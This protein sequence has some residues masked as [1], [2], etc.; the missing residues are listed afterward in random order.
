MAIDWGKTIHRL[1]MGVLL[2]KSAADIQKIVR[3]A[4]SHG[5]KVAMRGHGCSAY[6]QAQVEG[7]IVI[8]SA[9]LNRVTWASEAE[10]DCQPGATW[11]DALNMALERSLTPPVLPDTLF[12][13]IGGTLSVG[14]ISFSSYRHGGAVDHV[15]EI[16]VVTGTGELVTCSQSSRADL[17][18]AVLAGMG[19]CGLIVRARIKLIAAPRSVAVRRFTY[20]NRAQFLRDM[21]IYSKSEPQG[22]VEGRLVRERDGFK[23]VLRCMNWLFQSSEPDAPTWLSSMGGHMDGAAKVISY[24]DYAN[25]ITKRILDTEEH[26]AA[27]GPRPRVHAFV[28]QSAAQSMLDFLATDVDAALGVD[29]LPV[30]PLL[31][32]NFKMPL[33]RLPAGGLVFNMRL[34]RIASAEGGEDHLKM[35]K[36]NVEK[37]IP[38][39]LESGGTFYLPHTPVLTTDQFAQHFGPAGFEAFKVAKAKYDPSNLLNPGAGIFSHA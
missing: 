18:R 30:L 4:S 21:E 39:V 22:A 19:Q 7:G 9:D 6:G 34:Y 16:D 31:T 13:T 36:I 20:D 8:D 3:F 27:Q 12:L 26:E 11:F 1:P 25:A 35:L 17:F 33:M 38:R 10:I 32:A 14:G 5:F 23:P 37:V 24:S 2:P 29:D 28:S 15:S